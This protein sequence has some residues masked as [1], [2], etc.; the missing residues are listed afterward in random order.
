MEKRFGI[1]LLF[2]YF[3]I[4]NLNHRRSIMFLL[5]SVHVIIAVENG[6][7]AV[8]H[9]REVFDRKNR[10]RVC[11]LPCSLPALTGFLFVFISF[12]DFY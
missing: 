10:W 3:R 12:S 2:I 7:C 9:G 4:K 8:R 1:L 11:H 5:Q 6:K